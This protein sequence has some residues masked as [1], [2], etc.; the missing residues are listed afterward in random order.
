[1]K[2]VFSFTSLWFLMAVISA[3]SHSPIE[4]ERGTA[5]I[6]NEPETASERRVS[7]LRQAGYTFYKRGDY[8]RTIPYLEL[9]RQL[10][11]SNLTSNDY[12]V[13][14]YSYLTIGENQAAEAAIQRGIRLSPYQSYGYQLLGLAVFSMGK[15]GMAAEHF[16]R[17]L[18]FDSHPP[19]L[20]FYLGL[21]LEKMGDIKRR[22]QEYSKAEEKYEKI[23]L[24]N[25]YDFG[26]NFE[27]SYIYLTLGHKIPKVAELIGN[28]TKGLKESDPELIENGVLYSQF[29]LPLLGGMEAYRKNNYELAITS[30]SNAVLAG[31]LGARADLAEIYKYLTRSA[32]ELGKTDLAD[33]FA[34]L[35]READPN[36]ITASPHPLP[37]RLRKRIK[38]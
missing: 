6:G 34:K 36:S 33:T 10:G 13:L 20:H 25:V 37:K 23:L 1:M 14:G 3:C 31:P 22:D 7:D 12:F 21:A 16:K 17:G 35:E 18:E 29:Y 30:L 5:S 9:C 28:A 8:L 15:Y 26:A 19:K 11:E 38:K 24:Q 27:L 32:K 4:G 2:R